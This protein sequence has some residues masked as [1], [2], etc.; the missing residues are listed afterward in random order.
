MKTALTKSLFSYRT[1]ASKYAAVILGLFAGFAFMGA[2]NAVQ[3]G[4]VSV[5]CTNGTFQTG[6]D[7]SNPYFADKGNIAAHYCDIIQ[8]TGYVSDNL[9]DA[10][11]RYYLG[12]VPSPVVSPEPVVDTQ[13]TTSE[14]HTVVVE[15]S[16]VDTPTSGGQPE[17]SDT[18]S[19]VVETPTSTSQPVDSSTPSSETQP[20]TSTVVVPETQTSTSESSTLTIPQETATS[21]IETPLPTPPPV[22]EPQPVPQPVVV[23]PQ[24]EPQPEPE[25]EPLPEVIDEEVPLEEQPLEEQP[26]VEEQ[27][28][29]EEPSEHPVEE[30]THESPVEE[31][32]IQVQPEPTPEPSPQPV[33]V[34]EPVIQPDVA[35]DTPVV[36]LDNGVILSQEVAEQV[37]LLQN[38]AE[39][40][41][42]LF[43]DPMA[44]IAALG[45]VG[46]DMSPE[47]RQKSQDAVVQAVIVGSIVSQVA[48]AASY[49]RNP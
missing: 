40:L 43:T 45:A 26:V 5:T 19:V 17:S 44:A 14:T 21:P 27:L 3:T 16:P 10:S 28:P 22:V 37:E 2:A 33:V 42:E 8:H 38:P 48:A 25:P 6:W 36:I 41:T 34:P 35:I 18:S 32:E 23:M 1:K 4:V 9:T 29:V 46:A 47:A 13:T 39:L 15:P 20:D 12:I 7:N 24:P 31:P 11:L 49:R 30:D